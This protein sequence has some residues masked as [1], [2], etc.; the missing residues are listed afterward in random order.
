M[1]RSVLLRCGHWQYLRSGGDGGTLPRL[2]LRRR[3]DRRYQCRGDARPGKRHTL[4]NSMWL[5]REFSDLFNPVYFC[6]SRL[7]WMICTCDASTC[8][9]SSRWAHARVL[10]W[11]TTCGLPDSYYRESQKTLA[12]LSRSTRNRCL[13]TGTVRERTATSARSRW[14]R[15]EDW[16]EF[17]SEKNRESAVLGS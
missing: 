8:R 11:E 5:V 1:C 7:L 4:L 14:G 16:S 13:V 12:S 6:C 15:R 17:L 10:I 3:Q 2:S 9:R